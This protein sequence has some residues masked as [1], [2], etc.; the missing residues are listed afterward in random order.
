MILPAAIASKLIIMMVLVDNLRHIV[1]IL[2]IWIFIFEVFFAR[3]K[4]KGRTK[5]WTTT[6]WQLVKC[7]FNN[8]DDDDD[9]LTRDFRNLSAL[10]L[11]TY[12]QPH[13]IIHPHKHCA[14][15][16]VHYVPLHYYLIRNLSERSMIFKLLILNARSNIFKYFL[17]LFCYAKHLSS[18]LHFHTA[19]KQ[20]EKKLNTLVIKQRENESKSQ[21]S[22]SANEQRNVFNKLAF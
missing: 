12:T 6:P 10:T 22:Q 13:A 7:Y 9:D 1:K 16:L 18:V 21:E 19:L 2:V 3:K 15:V 5:K 14:A 20:W 11:N 17:M 8:N 4:E